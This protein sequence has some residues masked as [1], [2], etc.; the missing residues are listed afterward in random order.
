[1]SLLLHK[2]RVHREKR[3]LE[4][5]L[6]RFLLIHHTLW[7]LVFRFQ[8]LFLIIYDM[9]FFNYEMKMA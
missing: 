7:L 6:L 8:N 2:V 4:K 9:G 5:K 1:M 3:L